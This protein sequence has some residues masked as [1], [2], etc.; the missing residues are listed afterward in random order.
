[1]C[2]CP[3]GL[4]LHF[5]HVSDREVKDIYPMCQCPSGLILHFHEGKMTVKE[6]NVTCV[7]ALPGLYSIFTLTKSSPV[8][9]RATE[10]VFAYNYQNILKT[11]IFRPFFELA[12]FSS[13]NIEYL[14]LLHTQ[15]EY[16]LPHP[17]SSHKRFFF[18]NS[19][20]HS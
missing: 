10:G 2:Q 14:Y 16:S 5:H 7:N 11:S 17:S 13:S 12:S 18:Y 1:M 19:I 4:I 15:I 9:M 3:S 6:I 20:T 8:F